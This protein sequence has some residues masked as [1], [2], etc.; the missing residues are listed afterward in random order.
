[1]NNNAL[2]PRKNQNIKTDTGKIPA[3][4]GFPRGMQRVTRELTKREL[5]LQAKFTHNV[6]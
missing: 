1:M 2:T 3:N 6:K 4:V 5:K